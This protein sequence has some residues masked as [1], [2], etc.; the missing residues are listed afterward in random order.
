MC[1]SRFWRN[2]KINVCSTFANKILHKLFL[3]LF[4]FLLIQWTFFNT[5]KFSCSL[6]FI[7]CFVCKI[8]NIA[9][10]D[11]YEIV[12]WSY[13]CSVQRCISQQ[14]LRW[15]LSRDDGTRPDRGDRQLRGQTTWCNGT[16]S[17]DDR[18]LSTV[19]INISIVKV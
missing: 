11:S 6:N 14:S 13:T 15:L 17:R 8:S 3:V 2:L 18:I 9:W 16:S 5:V 1:I 12:T 4:C 10:L 19:I 7:N